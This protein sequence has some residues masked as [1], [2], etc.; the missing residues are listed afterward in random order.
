MVYYLV[1]GFIGVSNMIL[2]G[3]YGD[4]LVEKYSFAKVVRSIVFGIFW[5][6]L[7]HFSHPDAPLLVIA[8]ATIALE[9]ITTEIYKACIRVESQA[10]YLIPSNPFPHVP[11]VIRRLAGILLLISIAWAVSTVRLDAP[12]W[13]ITLVM[14]LSVALGGML[15]DAPHEGFEP[16]KFFRSPVVAGICAGAL[17]VLY[18]TLNMTLFFLAIAG[19]ERI[20]SEF[21]KKILHGRIPGKFRRVPINTHWQQSRH[22]VLYAYAADVVALA[23]LH[24]IR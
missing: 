16:L 23:M 17:W 11:I 15:K 22:L 19:A 1:A 12:L 3:L 2:W 5:S 7:L 24:F 8:L 9:R 13:V 18:P 10:K 4:L 21:Y 6:G 14:G 20:V